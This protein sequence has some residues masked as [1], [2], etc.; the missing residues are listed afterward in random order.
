SA[1]LKASRG[2]R[3]RTN[4]FPATSSASRKIALPKSEIV[5]TYGP[6]ATRSIQ[7]TQKFPSTSRGRPSSTTAGRTRAR[8]GAAALSSGEEADRWAAGVEDIAVMQNESAS[9]F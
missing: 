5:V 4:Q 7:T 9:Q 2:A 6:R 8:S 1:W 3:R